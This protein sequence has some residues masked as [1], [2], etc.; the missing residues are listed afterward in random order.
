[1]YYAVYDCQTKS[2][3]ATGYNETDKEQL[4]KDLIELLFHGSDEP[5]DVLDGLQLNDISST[6]EVIIEE[7]TEPFPDNGM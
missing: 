6:C 7:Q 3:L 5:E 1:M 2:F 4:R